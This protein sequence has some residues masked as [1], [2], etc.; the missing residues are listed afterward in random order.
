MSN[1]QNE[2]LLE[3]LFEEGL[4]LFD[5]DEDKAAKFARDRFDEL[6]EPDYK[7]HGGEVESMMDR[8][9]KKKASSNINISI[10]LN[11]GKGSE[12]NPSDDGNQR[13]IM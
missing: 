8:I 6:P 12:M 9:K 3:S 13:D 1:M 4:E 11:M 10:T 5:G 7:A 2:A